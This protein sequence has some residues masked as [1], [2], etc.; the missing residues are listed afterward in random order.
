MKKELLEMIEKRRSIYDLGSRKVLSE[1]RISEIV[2]EAVKYCPTAFNSQS[3]RV[4]VLFGENHQKLWDIVLQKLKEVAPQDGFAK[5]ELKI[6][7]F[8]AG[9]ATILFFEDLDAVED[10]QKKF[11]LYAEN[12]SKWSLQANGMLEYIVWTALEAE[13]AGAS[14]QH[15]N[16]LIDDDVKKTWN[17]P[18]KWQLLAQMPVGSIEAPAGDKSF[19]PID[20]RVKIFK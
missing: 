17:L 6:A 8:A 13:S 11:P 2:K 16:P 3:A 10:L 14:L 12:F 20:E 18:Q 9:Y 4:V 7:S 5:T 1:E 15:Y 19:L